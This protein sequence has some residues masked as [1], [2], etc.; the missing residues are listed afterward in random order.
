MITSV[1][2]GKLLTTI[3]LVLGLSWVAE[4]VDTRLAGILSGMPLG[5]L[6][7]LI[8]VGHDLGSEFAAES[9]LYGIPALVGTLTFA[10][11]YYLTSRTHHVLGP[12]IATLVGLPCYMVV[13]YTLSQFDFSLGGGILLTSIC[14]VLAARLF[15]PIPQERVMQRVRLT[16]WHLIF[17]AGMAAFFVIAITE[18]AEVIGSRWAGLLMGF[19]ITF[20]P[21]LLIIH[22]TYSHKHA[23][24]VIR[25][26]PV[27][28]GGLVCYLALIN[29]TVVSVGINFS[30]LIGLSGSLAYLAVIGYIFNRRQKGVN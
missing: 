1:I 7:V 25:N 4:R 24:T 13:A 15:A 9:A 16:F 29:T 18:I 11:V 14:I 20:L 5:S 8:F 26:F 2:L 21:F 28:L 12:L 3:A 10:G 19:P 27:G 23:H 22:I 17:R 6:L 30:I